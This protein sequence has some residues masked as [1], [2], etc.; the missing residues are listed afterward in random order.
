MFKLPVPWLVKT[1]AKFAETFYAHAEIDYP[2][3]P[4]SHNPGH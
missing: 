4:F 3:I 2:E 1:P